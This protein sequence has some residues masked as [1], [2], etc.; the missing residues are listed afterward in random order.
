MTGGMTILA[1]EPQPGRADTLTVVSE[2]P[3]ETRAVAALLGALLTGGEVVGL[4]G[5]LGAG[6]TC[7]AQGLARGLGVSPKAYVTSPTFALCN[8]HEGRV[9]LYHVDLYRLADADEATCIG[10]EDLFDGTAV[11]AI[12][13]FDR[14]P[15]LWPSGF[16]EISL[17]E[18]TGGGPDGAPVTPPSGH[19]AEDASDLPDPESCSPDS[20]TVNEV[21]SLVFHGIGER[22]QEIVRRLRGVLG[23][24]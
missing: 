22:H 7:F 11:V 12:E 15:E 17:R 13:W 2:S 23:G 24:S 1:R 20:Q 5:G 16:L 8:Q 9:P 3:G 6:K 10:Y 14:F 21:R 4:V 18:E 19:A